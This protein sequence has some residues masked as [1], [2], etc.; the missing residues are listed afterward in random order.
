MIDTTKTKR[1]VKKVEIALKYEL[2]RCEAEAMDKVAE[3]LEHAAR[4]QYSKIWYW[5]VNKLRE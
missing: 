1:N 3:D 2:R 5:H 4:R